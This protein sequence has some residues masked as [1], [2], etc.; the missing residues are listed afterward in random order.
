MNYIVNRT[1]FYLLI[2]ILLILPSVSAIYQSEGIS[3]TPVAMGTVKGDV[4]VFSTSGLVNPPVTLDLTFENEP[5][6]ARIYY[7]VWGGTEK[8]TGS[9][10]VT[11]NGRA[12]NKIQLYGED[13]MNPGVYVSSYGVYFISEEATGLLHAGQNR[14]TVE[15]SRGEPNSRIDGR[16]YGIWVVT[17]T[18][19]ESNTFTQYVLSEGN[20]NL[21]GEGWAGTNPTRKDSCTLRIKGIGTTGVT[22]ARLTILLLTGTRGQPD[23]VTFN[24]RDLGIAATPADEYPAGARDIGNERSNDAD[25]NTGTDTRYVDLETFDVT[26]LI[27]EVNEIRFER[28]RDLNGDGD[29]ST[30][31]SLPEGEDY[32]HPT[33]ALLAVTRSGQA[34]VPS[35]NLEG[36]EIKNA[37][38]GA[39][40]T[41]S[42][43]LTNAGVYTGSPVE[44]IYSVDGTPVQNDQVTVDRRGIRQVSTTWSAAGG[45]HTITVS[46][47]EATVSRQ[48][49]VGSPPVLSVSIGA[50]RRGDDSG[51]SGVPV[52]RAPLSILPVMTGLFAV[53]LL[54][55]RSSSRSLHLSFVLMLVAA[56][57]AGAVLLAPPAAAAGTQ[58]ILE[59]TVPVTVTNNGGSDATSFDLVLFLDGEKVAVRTVEGLAAGASDIVSFPIYTAPGT[60]ALVV[61]IETESLSGMNTGKAS[62]EG[63]YEFP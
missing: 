17:A 3:L 14:I 34:G 52:T 9:S 57:P 25:G 27:K 22:S 55:R 47:G 36:L 1:L 45:I 43:L 5:E 30:T 54:A 29:I 18:P 32:I 48:V 8:Y 51:T 53:C 49:E 4:Q 37:Y 15:T 6:F 46:A 31:G 11:I 62:A 16:V 63:A 39:E 40:A 59:Y 44:V 2:L 10:S 58:E 12:P 19:D 33:L 50:P 41:I 56:G 61:N 13:D 23:Y 7:A 38:T 26:G 20:E 28:G 21:H 42:A 35:Y 60:H 24:G